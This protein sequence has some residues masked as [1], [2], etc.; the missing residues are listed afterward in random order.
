MVVRNNFHNS[1]LFTAVSYLHVIN[2]YTFHWVSYFRDAVHPG[3]KAVKG[4]LPEQLFNVR[5]VGRSC[6]AVA[7]KRSTASISTL[8]LSGRQVSYRGIN[9][10]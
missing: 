9:V 10:G 6:P 1:N 4:F 3:L 5:K 2:V 8:E 7:R